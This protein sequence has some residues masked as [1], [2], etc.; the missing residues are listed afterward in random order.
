MCAGRKKNNESKSAFNPDLTQLARQASFGDRQAFIRWM[1][2]AHTSVHRLVIRML[3][4]EQGIDDLIQEV[5][6][7]AW[8]NITSLKNP[9]VSLGWVC[10]IARNVTA[11]YINHPSR[12]ELLMLDKMNS[13]GFFTLLHQIYRRELDPE[14]LVVSNENVERMRFAVAG[15]D[16]KYRE[17][18]LLRA[19]KGMSY[20][21]I[22]Q[23]VGI[24]LGTVE[25]R[26]YRARSMLKKILKRRI[27]KQEKKKE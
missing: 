19:V 25:N 24:P 17:V 23:A 21:E 6:T 12:R 2:K 5:F 4:E 10:R 11:N 13:A 16:L 27:H 1:D 7:R 20:Q 9:E 15:L 3:G 22:G 14:A 18:L 8:K 26:L